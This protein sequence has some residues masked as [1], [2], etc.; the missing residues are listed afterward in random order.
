MIG[1]KNLSFWDNRKFSPQLQLILLL[2][3]DQFWFSWVLQVSGNRQKPK[4]NYMAAD[5]TK[6]IRLWRDC[7]IF[8]FVNV[9]FSQKIQHKVL[10]LEIQLILSI[11]WLWDLKISAKSK[12][13]SKSVKNDTCANLS[14]YHLIF[15]HEPIST[16]KSPNS[17][18]VNYTFYWKLKGDMAWILF[19]L[20]NLI[21]ILDFGHY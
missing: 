2:W 18:K 19:D 21:A 4:G 8:D 13:L 6:K 17:A 14:C 12:K 16:Q 1:F 7:R 20:D 15:D 5:Y 10:S 3:I 11:L 9:F